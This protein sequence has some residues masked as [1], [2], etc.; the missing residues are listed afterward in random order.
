MR[1]PRVVVH[2]TQGKHPA[3]MRLSVDQHPVR[4]LG[5]DGQHEPFGEAVRPRTPGRGLDRL[6]TRI[7]EH[8][9]EE[10]R[11]LPAIA[12]QEPEPARRFHQDP[13]RDRGPAA[14]RACRDVRSHP[15]GDHQS[16]LGIGMCSI[17]E[18]HTFPP[19]ES[20]RSGGIAVLF[21]CTGN[22]AR[23]PLSRSGWERITRVGWRWRPAPRRRW[24]ASRFTDE[25]HRMSI[26]GQRAGSAQH[27]V[28]P[29]APGSRCSPGR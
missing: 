22:S 21:V 3:E 8:R 10:D 20:R 14:S 12:D 15:A 13:S 16:P 27:R 1:P 2:G 9:I 7:R 17:V 26:D 29:V 6:D 11:E 23:S 5:P 24:E 28:G 4:E 25:E 18:Q 19:V